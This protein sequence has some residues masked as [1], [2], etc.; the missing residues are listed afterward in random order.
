MDGE[1][2]FPIDSAPTP[3]CHAATIAET[4]FGLVAA[5]FG[6]TE[7]KNKDV[8]IYGAYHTGD[9][10]SD[11]AILAKDD[12]HPCWNPVLF[13]PSDGPLMLFYKVG[14]NVRKWWGMVRTYHMSGME[15]QDGSGW[16]E[17]RKLGTDPKIGHLIGPAKNK[18]IQWG[19]A[20]ICGSSTQHDGWRVHFEMSRDMGQTW[21]VIGPMPGDVQAIQP[22][23]FFVEG[24]VDMVMGI[25]RNKKGGLSQCGFSPVFKEPGPLDDL[26]AGHV[27]NSGIDVLPP[28]DDDNYLICFNL[29]KYPGQREYRKSRHCLILAKRGAEPGVDHVVQILEDGKLG[30]EYSYP[31][32]I[33]D[34]EGRIH[35]VYTY[36]RQTIKH[37]VI[38]P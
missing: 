10:W 30:E 8:N 31:S 27:M 13:Q 21:E 19:D 25:C 38:T 33:E 37:V 4:P 1:F 20:I 32:M 24:L 16:S 29:N 5:W 35:V 34:G 14:P 6:G 18:P 23:M 7:E 28:G 9:E 15:S 12:K 22:A 11:P 2:I 17:P 3:M 36:N 26:G